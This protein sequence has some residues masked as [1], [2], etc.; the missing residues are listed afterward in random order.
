MNS[1]ER[2]TTK[3]RLVNCVNNNIKT[4]NENLGNIRLTRNQS[5][6]K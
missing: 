6:K 2:K 3:A 1:V 5:L 4:S